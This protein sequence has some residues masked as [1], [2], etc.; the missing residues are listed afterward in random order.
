M[1]WMLAILVC[2]APAS[3]FAEPDRDSG[4]YAASRCVRISNGLARHEVAT[5][6]S[7]TA[8][9]N[10]RCALCRDAPNHYFTK[11]DISLPASTEAALPAPLDLE[12][13]FGLQQRAGVIANLDCHTMAARLDEP[14]PHRP[15]QQGA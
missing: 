7:P 12:C 3:V 15:G 11:F 2:L 8:C 14:A 1:R 13:K 6:N 9:R 10:L 5:A 4:N